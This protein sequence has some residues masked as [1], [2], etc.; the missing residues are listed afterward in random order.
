MAT[1][2]NLSEEEKFK[3]KSLNLLTLKPMLYILNVLKGVDKYY[4]VI[5]DAENEDGDEEGE[6]VIR[7]HIRNYQ[8]NDAEQDIRRE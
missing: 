7:Y 1:V 6:D 8:Q 3:I 2:A 4:E 5:L